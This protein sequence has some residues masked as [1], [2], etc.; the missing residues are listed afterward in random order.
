[1]AGVRG[2]D[3]DDGGGV[4]RRRRERSVG[5]GRGGGGV[6]GGHVWIGDELSGRRRRRFG[7]FYRVRPYDFFCRT[8]YMGAAQ[9]LHSD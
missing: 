5:K 2:E 3:D 7:G 9:L 1:M 6:L 8:R 4:G